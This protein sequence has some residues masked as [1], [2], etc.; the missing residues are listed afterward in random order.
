MNRYLIPIRCAVLA[1]T[2]FFAGC[3]P[4]NPLADFIQRMDRLP[5]EQRV[6]NWEQTRRLVTRTAPRVG[7]TAPDFTLP[8]LDGTASITR[9]VHQGDRP[10]VLMF[11]NYT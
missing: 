7:E 8:T 4:K 2:L 5:P 6:P 1:A 11:G 10:L 9:S 3:A